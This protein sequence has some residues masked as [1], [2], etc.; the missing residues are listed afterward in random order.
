MEIEVE[1]TNLEEVKE[2]LEAK[3]DMILLDNFSEEDTREAVQLIGKQAKIEFSGGV[4][5]SNVRTIAEMGVD[6][7]SVGQLTHSAPNFDF[8][9]LVK[10]VY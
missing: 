10:E 4:N 2:A 6:R 7:I 9:L 8:S 1:V 3:A 5:L